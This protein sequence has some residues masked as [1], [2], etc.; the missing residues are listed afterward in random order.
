M[1]NLVVRKVTARLLKF[2]GDIS[3]QSLMKETEENHENHVGHGKHSRNPPS[4][5]KKQAAIAA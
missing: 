4:P 3:F 2:K 1:L 5:P